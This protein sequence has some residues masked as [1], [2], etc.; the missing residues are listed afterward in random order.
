MRFRLRCASER[1]ERPLVW[2]CAPVPDQ[3]AIVLKALR[4]GALALFLLVSPTA[5]ASSSEPKSD[6]HV[7][8][9]GAGRPVAQHVESRLRSQIRRDET[10]IQFFGRHRWLL[11]DPR[12]RA[13][14]QREL[15]SH[16]HHLARARERL[17]RMEQKRRLARRLAVVKVETPQQ[18]IC[19]VFGPYCGEA[20]RVAQCESGFRTDAQNG[21]YLGL[22]QMGYE[23]R[24]L[25]GHGPTAEEQARA[26]Y[27]YFAASGRNWTPWSCKP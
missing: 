6:R 18:V 7:L 10:V 14:A 5:L 21:Q 25:F 20:L 23:E 27:R 9:R 17:H 15:A 12:F 22:F 11:T 16:R 19:R 8:H 26:A 2:G 1:H 13:N 24:R 4:L 3:E